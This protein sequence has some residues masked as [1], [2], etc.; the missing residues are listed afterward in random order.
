MQKNKAEKSSQYDLVN[1]NV[2]TILRCS[3]PGASSMSIYRNTDKLVDSIVEFFTS[4]GKR[5]GK[6]SIAKCIKD[7]ETIIERDDLYV[8]LEYHATI[9]GQLI[10]CYHL[11]KV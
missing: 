5:A 6:K 2:L 3:S 4:G 8:E 10:D 11:T 1:G 7:T 9:L